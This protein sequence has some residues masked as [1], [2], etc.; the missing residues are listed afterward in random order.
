MDKTRS[1]SRY[2]PIENSERKL[3]REEFIVF[4]DNC[5][6]FDKYYDE[7]TARIDLTL[8]AHEENHPDR[9]FSSIN[10]QTQ[11]TVRGMTMMI[12]STVQ[13]SHNQSKKSIG[14]KRFTST[15]ALKNKK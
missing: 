14:V 2:E 11:N 12:D 13:D 15:P 6:K 3:R 9:D 5:R 10:P 7:E 8:S 1:Q 4:V